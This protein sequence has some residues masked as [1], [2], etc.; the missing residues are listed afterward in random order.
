MRRRLKSKRLRK[1][2]RREKRIE[3]T[4]TIVYAGPMTDDAKKMLAWARQST[5]R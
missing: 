2:H 1:K 5:P 4:I 3:P